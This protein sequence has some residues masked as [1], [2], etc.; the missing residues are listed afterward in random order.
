MRLFRDVVWVFRYGFY[1]FYLKMRNRRM[2]DVSLD[3]RYLP[4]GSS[5][6]DSPQT[7]TYGSLCGL[8]SINSEIFVKFPAQEYWLKL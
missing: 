4:G 5:I 7:E 8:A 3:A 6:T 1:N 2:F